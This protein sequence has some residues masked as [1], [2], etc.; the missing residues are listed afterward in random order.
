MMMRIVKIGLYAENNFYRLLCLGAVIMFL[1]QFTINLGSAL[2][3]LPVI[4]ITFPFLSYG[5]SSLLINAII[6]GIVESASVHR[7][8]S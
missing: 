7:S 3:L 4:G 2:G 8:L 1:A 5:G 6:I